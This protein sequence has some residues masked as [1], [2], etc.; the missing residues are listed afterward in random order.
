MKPSLARRPDAPNRG[1]RSLRWLLTPLLVTLL[2]ACSKPDAPAAATPIPTP[3]ASTAV[4]PSDGASAAT[5]TPA[6]AA[7][8]KAQ[9][10]SGFSVGPVIGADPVLVLFD[11]QCPHCAE[12]W[13]AAQPLLGKIKMV[14]MPVGFLRETS[15]PQ[16][17]MILTASDPVAK[18]NE[19]EKLLADRQGGL[20]VPSDVDPQAIAKVQAN[21]ELLR[22][23]GAD[24][25]PYVLY[26]NHRTGAYAAG[27]GAMSTEQLSAAL[28]L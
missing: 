26:R 9:A 22:T 25:V 3:P 27:A 14:W 19:Q 23:L 1:R 12:L 7:Y 20:P 13:A 11:P 16:G 4:A 6:E 10:G 18:M 2:A 21:T 5:A 8:R 28:G 15:T 24:S 17:A